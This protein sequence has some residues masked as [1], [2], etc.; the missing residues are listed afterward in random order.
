MVY[1]LDSGRED[2]IITNWDINHVSAPG[3][4]WAKYADAIGVDKMKAV[5]GAA[6]PPSTV[7]PGEAVYS[8][9]DAGTYAPP[10]SPE[11]RPAA[12]ISL[13]TDQFDPKHVYMSRGVWPEWHEHG[14]GKWMRSWATEIVCSEGGDAISIW[15]GVDSNPEHFENVRR[16]DFWEPTGMLFS[17]HMVMFTHFL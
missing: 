1:P 17:P 9:R 3:L 6:W 16:D 10:F 5:Y 15:I 2:S 7:R 12:W 11:G 14:L 4:L 13:T 8:V